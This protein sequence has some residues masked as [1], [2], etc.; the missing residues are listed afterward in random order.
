MCGLNSSRGMIFAMWLLLMGNGSS[1]QSCRRDELVL[2]G[3]GSCQTE[4]GYPSVRLG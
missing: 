3:K 1:A 4:R 2:D